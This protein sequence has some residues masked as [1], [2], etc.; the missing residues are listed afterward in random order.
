MPRGNGAYLS[1]LSL[2]AGIPG[3][4][5]VGYDPRWTYFPPALSLLSRAPADLVHTTPDHA[6]FFARRGTPLVVTFRSYF[7]DAAVRPYMST[8]QRLHY[9]GDLAW[10]TRRAL[11]RADCVTC[12]SEYLKRRVTADLGYAGEVPVI[13]NGVDTGR[14]F[15]A[16]S[17]P[18]KTLR[19]LVV[20]KPSL[21]KGFQFLPGIA[22]RLRPG[23]EILYTNIW[24]RD[25][26]L[27]P[28]DRLRRVGPVAHDRM[29]DLYRSA[30]I[31]LFPTVREGFG[32]A[33]LEAMASGIPVVASE[34]SALP[35]LIVEG[36]GG[37]LC[38]VGDVE[39][40]ADRINRLS[41]EPSLRL[42]FGEFN[43]ERAADRFP[44][45][46]MIAGYNALFEA[47]LDGA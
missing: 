28:H 19:V 15:P 14:F 34:C 2:E 35:E 42:R 20:G 43:R 38:P 37:F 18:G 11:R 22:D 46:R 24:A 3:Y 9:S 47:V 29:P 33:A 17:R 40:F 31:F 13:Y 44:M 41:R 1:H 10:F 8:T 39:A 30:D 27:P 16:R 23:T 5:V 26:F 32:R 21:R 7:L 6:I 12:A 45:S 25:T 4:E 36:K